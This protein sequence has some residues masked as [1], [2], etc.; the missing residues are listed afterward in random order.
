[1]PLSDALACHG[2]CVVQYKFDDLPVF[3]IARLM[4]RHGIQRFVSKLPFWWP[5]IPRASNTWPTV[6]EDR[7][8]R[9][10]S[11][12]SKFIQ[13]ICTLALNCINTQSTS[14]MSVSSRL[15]SDGSRIDFKSSSGH[16]HMIGRNVPHMHY[17]SYRCIEW[18]C[19]PAEICYHHHTFGG[20]C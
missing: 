8:F 18:N 17:A 7:T 2:N 13:Q 19:K 12:Q 1:M 10:F 20:G 5:V 14:L 3:F 6:V 4:S 15:E 9:V 16:R 11:V